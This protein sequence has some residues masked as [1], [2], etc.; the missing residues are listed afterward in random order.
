[1][2]I[3][4]LNS[5]FFFM[6][7]LFLCFIVNNL[8]PFLGFFMCRCSVEDQ[9]HASARGS[10]LQSPVTSAPCRLA[11]NTGHDYLLGHLSLRDP[12]VATDIFPLQGHNSEF[13][14]NGNKLLSGKCWAGDHHRFTE[15][16]IRNSCK[17]FSILCF[18][19]QITYLH[20]SLH[21]T[22][23]PKVFIHMSPWA[24]A[25]AGLTLA[26]CLCCTHCW[27]SIPGSVYV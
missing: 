21:T 20:R 7:F 24:I 13:L 9:R 12:D 22:H 25:K 10:P 4:F 27:Y 8:T 19:L 15:R 11:Q 26:G 17:F 1:M 14:L 6:C 16:E 18:F 3:L 23:I 2:Y 5:F